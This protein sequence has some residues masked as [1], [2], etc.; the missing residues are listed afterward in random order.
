M[1]RGKYTN[2]MSRASFLNSDFVVGSARQKHFDILSLIVSLGLRADL[3]V[4]LP[5]FPRY[6][7]DFQQ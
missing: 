3:A 2:R 1:K 5:F 7:F 4:V 6:A